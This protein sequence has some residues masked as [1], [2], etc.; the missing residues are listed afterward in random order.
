MSALIL[1][2]RLADLGYI[3]EPSNDA[4]ILTNST[5][6]N[7]HTLE[8]IAKTGNCG[9]VFFA[10]S[11]CVY[12]DVFE[13]DP[14]SAERLQKLEPRRLR[15][16]DARFE[17]NFAFAKEKLYAESLYTAYSA[18][19]G[20]PVAIAR[21]GNCYGPYCEWKE[22]RSKAVAAICRKVAEAAYG[23]VVKLWGD[24]QQ[25]RSFTY[26]DDAVEGII[27]LMASDY[28]KPLNIASPETATIEQLFDFI[29]FRANKIL[30][31]ESEPGPVGVSSRA[32]DNSLCREILD[33]EPTTS[34]PD[35]LGPTYDWVAKQVLEKVPA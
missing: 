9:K 30:A 19:H 3:G 26:V 31:W 16:I 12:P 24:G 5:K 25:S 11:Q 35:G 32:S 21:L 33:W 23:G 17:H 1:L 34:L 6:V 4:E 10:S 15:E 18:A 7:L 20:F 8:A 29:C 22:P 27:R 2:D 28:D 13:I 14:F